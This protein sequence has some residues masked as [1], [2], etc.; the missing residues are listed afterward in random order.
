M[1]RTLGLLMICCT[2]AAC[3]DSVASHAKVSESGGA[4][5]TVVKLGNLSS[6]APADWKA[7]KP[8]SNLRLYQ[9]K[10]PK[11]SGDAEDADLAIFFFEGGAG[12]AADN[13]K[14]WQGMFVPPT[15]KSIDSVSKI[16]KFKVGSAQV[17]YLDVAGTFQSKNPPFDPKAKTETKPE[18]RRFGVIFEVPGSQ[19]FLTLT[20]PAKTM[21]QHKK[22]F[23]EWLKNF[24]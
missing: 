11:V 12:S 24:K 23:D 6:T 9:F 19:Y 4:Q 8:S 3:H 10:L 13:I 18:F 17:T 21:E 7:E 15:G 20:G 2:A 22:S 5:G 1:K 16:D 14:R